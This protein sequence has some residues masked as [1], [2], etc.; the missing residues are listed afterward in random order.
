MA[1]A[2]AQAPLLADQYPSYERILE[3]EPDLVV[4]G[5]ASAFDDTTGG[6][7]KRWRS[8]GLERC[9]SR[10]PAPRARPGW[11]RC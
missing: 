2:Y 8:A 10:S 1:A 6:T 4:G 9:C 5:Y 11:T 7:G 3:A